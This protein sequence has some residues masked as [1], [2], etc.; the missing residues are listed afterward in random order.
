M[1]LFDT[2]IV[3]RKLPLTKEIKKAFP[4]KDWTKEDF[5]TKS[6][7]NTMT[8]YYIKKNGFLYTE[9]VEGEQVR[10]MTE[11]EE[12]KIRKQGRFCWPYK[13]VEHSRESV[14]EIITDTINFYSYENDEEGNTWDIEFDAEIIK[15]KLKS[16][17][18][19]KAEIVHTAEENAANEK[20]WQDRLKAYE[21]HPWTK[22]KKILNKIT[23][24]YWS[25]FWGNRVSRALYWIAQKIQ[26][27]QLWVIRNLA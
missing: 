27:L 17:K 14:K 5:Q 8:S 25:K 26:K 7:D 16:L 15:G 19:V 23:F 2:I 11:A 3:K 22:T 4:N 21:N 12:K 20:A 24:N 10:T 18:L 13:F 6:L 1:G 9:K